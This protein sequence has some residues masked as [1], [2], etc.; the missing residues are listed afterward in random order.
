MFV[1]SGTL[2]H[3]GLLY[4]GSVSHIFTVTMAWLRNVVR[5]D[6][7]SVIKVFFLF[8]C[9]LTTTEVKRICNDTIVIGYHE[10]I[11]HKIPVVSP[12]HIQPCKG[13][14]CAYK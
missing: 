14:G 11:Y 10:Q 13:C 5:C 4:W 8:W 9:F 3:R 6:G 1:L 12:G 7:Y 2:S